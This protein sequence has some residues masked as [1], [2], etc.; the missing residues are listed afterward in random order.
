MKKFD[1][2]SKHLNNF[3]HERTVTW[4]HVGG[5]EGTTNIIFFNISLASPAA[6]PIYTFLRGIDGKPVKGRKFGSNP[7]MSPLPT[8]S[9]DSTPKE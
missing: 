9:I 6:S 8:F 3:V 4:I 1:F 5:N 7:L 2:S